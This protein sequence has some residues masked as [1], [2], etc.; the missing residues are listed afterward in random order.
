MSDVTVTVRMP[1]ALRDR[2]EALSTETRRSKSFL[3]TEAIQQFVETEEEIVLGIR[4]AQAELKSGHGI[5]HE[6]V[7]RRSRTYLDAKAGQIAWSHFHPRP[8]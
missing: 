8:P 4:Q 1:K 7:V 3:V 6:D 5:P 2:L